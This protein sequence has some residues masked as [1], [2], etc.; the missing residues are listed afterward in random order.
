MSR[1]RHY[2]PLCSQRQVWLSKLRQRSHVLMVVG[3]LRCPLTVDLHHH[4]HLS[5][6]SYSHPG[7][8][9]LCAAA[10]VWE[11][12]QPHHSLLLPLHLGVPLPPPRP[13]L[14][15]LAPPLS[16]VD[17]SRTLCRVHHH[18]WSSGSLLPHHLFH[19]PLQ[20]TH[21]SDPCHHHLLSD[22]GAGSCSHAPLCSSPVL[23]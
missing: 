13:S 20:W 7:S 8:L 23:L 21:Y 15:V 12:I 18:Y 2:L 3:R 10:G 9:D 4:H 14:L 5:P 22:P 19:H 6:V 1:A 16:L 11:R 17:L